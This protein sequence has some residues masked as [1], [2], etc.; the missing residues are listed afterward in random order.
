M[1]RRLVFSQAIFSFWAKKSHLHKVIVGQ[2]ILNNILVVTFLRQHHLSHELRKLKSISQ[3]SNDRWGEQRSQHSEMYIKF[4][5]MILRLCKIT[6]NSILIIL[7]DFISLYF[8]WNN[9]NIPFLKM[10][11]NGNATKKEFFLVFRAKNNENEFQNP[12]KIFVA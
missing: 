7:H 2:W 12:T 6:I 1:K 3:S 5:Q 11:W 9:R 10:V 8:K 4:L